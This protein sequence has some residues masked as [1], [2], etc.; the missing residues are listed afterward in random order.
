[1]TSIDFARWGM[2]KTKTVLSLDQKVEVIKALETK[3]QMQVALQ[4][5]ISQSSVSRIKSR[6]CDILDNWQTMLRRSSKSSY[7][8]TDVSSADTDSSQSLEDRCSSGKKGITP[9]QSYDT[10]PASPLFLRAIG[11]LHNFNGEHISNLA[12]SFLQRYCIF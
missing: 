9:K 7:N 1:M 11:S 8:A 4:Y 3:S 6:E 10:Q 5:G 2:T 12:T